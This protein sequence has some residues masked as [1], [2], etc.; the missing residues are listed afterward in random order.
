MR[1]VYTERYGALLTGA[2]RWLD[3]RLDVRPVDAGLQTVGYLLDGRSA[4]DIVTAA[5]ARG[6]EVVALGRYATS[7][8]V[9]DGLQLGFAAVPP[10][11]IVRGIQGLAQVLEPRHAPP[12]RRVRRPRRPD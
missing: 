8:L 9:R 12:A 2:R 4:P 6:V 10:A 1:E 3:G 7:P 11:E 5:A